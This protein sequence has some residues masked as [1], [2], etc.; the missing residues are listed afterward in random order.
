MSDNVTSGSGIDVNIN[1]ETHSEEY[2]EEYTEATTELIMN[3]TDMEIKLLKAENIPLCGL[4]EHKHSELCYN[5]A[6]MLI[7]DTKEHKHD[8]SC[9][10]IMLMSLDDT[11]NRLILYEG[12][13]YKI[14]L[15][16]NGS[17]TL[18][19]DGSE[20]PD[21]FI[22]SSDLSPYADNISKI[23]IKNNVAKIGSG[24]LRE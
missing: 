8:N 13:G 1:V 11:E 5:E 17:Y 23:I 22:S 20:I 10:S 19:F 6:G 24:P 14:T 16:S 9:Y 21:G 12:Y 3:D 15:N 4:P 7:C 18:T 2:A